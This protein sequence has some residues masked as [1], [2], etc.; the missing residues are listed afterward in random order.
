MKKFLIC[1]VALLSASVAQA[2]TQNG[3]RFKQDGS[4]ASPN[5]TYSINGTT[6]A[7]TSK[8]V[9]ANK[10]SVMTDATADAWVTPLQSGAYSY[11]ESNAAL[12]SVVKSDGIAS[13]SGAHTSQT[14]GDINEAAIA[15]GTLCAQ[16]RITGATGV[17]CFYGTAVRN[18]NTSAPTHAVELDIDNKGPAA[19]MYPSNINPPGLTN[20]MR[21]MAGGEAAATTDQASSAALVI[22]SNDPTYTNNFL[23]GIIFHNRAIHGTDGATGAGN[24]ITL[25]TGQQ[26]AWYRNDNAPAGYFICARGA[27]AGGDC[28]WGAYNASGSSVNVSLNAYGDNSFAPSTPL[29]LGVPSNPWGGVYTNGVNISG[30]EP[31]IFQNA[32]G[33]Y[34][35]NELLLRATSPGENILSLQNDSP[36]GFSSLTFRGNDLNSVDTTKVF[37]HMAIGWSNAGGLNSIESSTFDNTADP[38]KAPARFMI[39]QTGGVDPTGGTVISCNTTKGSAVVTCASAVPAASSGLFIEGFGVPDDTTIASG[40]G[41]TTPTLTNVA[42]A[43]LSGTGLRFSHPVYAQHPVI[44]MSRTGSWWALDWS[45]NY[46]TT[47]DRNKRY[48]GVNTGFPNTELDAVGQA[49]FGNDQTQRWKNGN[50][51]AALNVI[52]SGSNQVHLVRPTIGKLDVKIEGSTGAGVVNWYDGNNGYLA[53]AMPLDGKGGMV[54]HQHTRQILGT[55][56]SDTASA[57]DAFILWNSTAAAPKAQTVPE[58]TPTLNGLILTIVDEANT[59]ATYPIT[60]TPTAGQIN[61]GPN[62]VISANGSSIRMVCDGAENWV[63]F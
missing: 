49:A 31:H 40:G 28:Q 13:F 6:G 26:M 57:L 14:G 3:P 58:C 12:S 37:E 2:Q 43:T 35:P 55:L 56:A 15:N 20:G 9:T 36:N 22:G 45:G 23:N 29:N 5:G 30:A 4:V 16:D 38:G 51:T 44:D 10:A 7:V 17:W 8:S 59:A 32:G 52:D 62:R 60:V 46:L 25:A 21:I 33:A 1:A 47:W 61:F 11:L 42:N 54:V 53:M 27:T 18:V 50:I 19:Y 34:S 39:Q 63:S 41:T 48:F 24:A